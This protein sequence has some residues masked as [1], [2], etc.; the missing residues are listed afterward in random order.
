MIDTGDVRIATDPWFAGPAYSQQWYVFPKPVNPQAVE[1][2]NAI[3]ISH[4]HEDHFHPKTLR[5]LANKSARVFY[6]YTWFGGAKEFI[7]GLGFSNVT[8]AVSRQ[9]YQLNKATSITYIANGHDHIIVIESGGEVLVNVNDALHSETDATI[10]L[11]IDEIRRRWPRIDALFCGF[12]GASYFPNMLH[13]AGKDDRETGLVREQ[14]FA[15]NFCRVVAG[16]K[17]HVAVP[18]AADFALLAPAERWIN[19][20]RFPRSRLQDYFDR[21]FADATR[22]QP[23]QVMYPGDVLDGAELEPCSVYRTQL[24]D[25]E[26][27]HLIDEQYA[28]E[29]ARKQ[30]PKLMSEAEVEALANDLGRHV[31]SRAALLG[32]SQLRG[33]KF[34]INL[35]DA[36]E[37]SSFNIDFSNG[38]AL[39]RRATQPD[40]DCGV[41]I[42]APSRILRYAMKYEFG[43]DAIGIG[44]G[45]HFHLR[46][47]QQA[48]SNLDQVCYQ[49][50]TRVTTRR[51]YLRQNPRRVL[52]YLIR[53]PPL[54][55][56]QESAARA[57][58]VNYDRSI[59]LLYEA[60]ELRKKF[61]LATL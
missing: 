42:D 8:E 61:G 16:L 60:E 11:F 13:V 12:G 52:S 34:G 4:G 32:S 48:A 26:L 35:S 24:H 18:F 56:R 19:D 29:I 58:A 37:G 50:L 44:Y 45:A 28:D 47:R 57:A 5:G 22:N 20:V 38:S 17:P 49:L 51:A 53:H 23:I 41:V 6:P 54:G 1:T 2:A 3:A 59:W 10:D 30:N 7:Q 33:L 39:L 43:G 27:T 14:L 46:D 15:R 25:G 36:A 55:H 40:D 31:N 21:Y 9:K